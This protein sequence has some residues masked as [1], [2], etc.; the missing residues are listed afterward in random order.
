MPEPERIDRRRAVPIAGD[1]LPA[2]ANAIGSRAA[3]WDA[4]CARYLGTD[5][6]GSAGGSCDKAMKMYARIRRLDQVAAMLL[7]SRIL[8]ARAGNIPGNLRGLGR[9]YR[10]APGV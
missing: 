3:G 2:G 9:G 7:G 4:P 6:R 10:P 8:I 5:D 1:V